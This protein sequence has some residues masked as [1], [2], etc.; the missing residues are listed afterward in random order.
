[1]NRKKGISLEILKLPFWVLYNIDSIS[2]VSNSIN[3]HLER[4]GNSVVEPVGVLAA[5][6][7]KEWLSATTAL[8]VFGGLPYYLHSI[9]PFCHKVV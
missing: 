4:F 9:E 1:M 7:S 3:S 2:I 6:L 8:Y 5:R